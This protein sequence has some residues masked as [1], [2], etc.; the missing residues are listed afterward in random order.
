MNIMQICFFQKRYNIRKE[1]I[2]ITLQNHVFI[3]ST[4]NCVNYAHTKNSIY[5]GWIK[6][7]WIKFS[8]KKM[9]TV[10]FL[11]FALYCGDYV[12]VMCW[13]ACP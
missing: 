6:G 13:Q 4:D 2:I 8:H 7:N 5:F 9:F 11:F 12:E 3:A 10:F 1:Y